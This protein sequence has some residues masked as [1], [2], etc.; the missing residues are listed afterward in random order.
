MPECILL[1]Q[2][3]DALGLFSWYEQGWRGC[4]VGQRWKIFF[5]YTYFIFHHWLAFNLKAIQNSSEWY[6]MVSYRILPHTFKHVYTVSHFLLQWEKLWCF[7]FVWTHIPPRTPLPV[8]SILSPHCVFSDGVELTGA[9]SS[10]MSGS[11][12]KLQNTHV[13]VTYVFNHL[14][15][16]LCSPACSVSPSLPRFRVSPPQPLFSKCSYFPSLS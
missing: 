13:Q 2:R 6:C 16:S 1:K 10:T 8:L 4:T 11:K 15:D 14:P 12:D 5:N 7:W 3:K 9:A